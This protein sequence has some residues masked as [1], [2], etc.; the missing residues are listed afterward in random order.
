[1]GLVAQGLPKLKDVLAEIGLFDKGVGPQGFHQVVLQDDPF[2]ALHKHQKCLKSL[3]REGD[4][5]LIAH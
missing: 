4:G 3:G 1:M 5:F 2:T